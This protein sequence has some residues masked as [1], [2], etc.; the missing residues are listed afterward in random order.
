MPPWPWARTAGTLVTGI[1]APSCVT[2]ETRPTFSVI[3]MR[4]SGRNA[5]RQGRLNV[6]TFVIVNGMV[7]SAC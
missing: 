5:M 1:F 4:P 2:S 6:A 3:N 7:A